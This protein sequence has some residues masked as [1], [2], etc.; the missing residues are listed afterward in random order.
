MGKMTIKCFSKL[1][2]L[3]CQK[4][5]KKARRDYCRR[6]RRQ[7][8]ELMDLRQMGVSS[9]KRNRNLAKVKIGR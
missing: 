4:V 7:K 2:G 9:E 1:Y 3:G 5:N 8:H 6:N